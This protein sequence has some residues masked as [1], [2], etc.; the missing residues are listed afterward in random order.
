MT[1]YRTSVRKETGNQ[2][3][4]AWR[5]VAAFRRMIPSLNAYARAMTGRRDVR[6][7][8]SKTSNGSTD[9]RVISYRP[10][11]S[12]GR[13][14]RHDTFLCDER[15]EDLQ[16]LCPAC[17]Q[18]EDVLAVIYHEIAHLA[19][20]TFQKPPQG[21]V[22]GLLRAAVGDGSGGLARRAQ[23]RL[24]SGQVFTSYMEVANV[25]SPWLPHVFNA[26]EDA[27]VNNLMFKARPGV[28]LMFEALVEKVRQEGVGSVTAHGEEEV[29]SWV[30]APENSQ[31]VTA[32]FMYVAGYDYSDMFVESVLLALDDETLSN[33]LA[34]FEEVQTAQGVYTLSLPILV[35]CQQLGFLATPEEQEQ[36][37]LDYG[38]SDATGTEG[39]QRDG[40][41]PAPAVA[42]A[43]DAADGAS[44]A[45][46][47]AEGLLPAGSGGEYQAHDSESEQE[48]A[49]EAESR[50]SGTSGISTE[51]E[52][53][54]GGDVP[55]SGTAGGTDESSRNRGDPERGSLILD[56]LCGYFSLDDEDEDGEDDVREER[57]VCHGHFDPDAGEGAIVVALEQSLYFEGPSREV[58][59]L[60][61]VT[62]ADWECERGSNYYLDGAYELGSELLEPPRAALGQALLVMR[63][64]FTKNRRH[65]KRRNLTAGHVDASRLGRR[66]AVG[67]DRLFGK[68]SLPGK[69]SYD[70][71]I[72]LDCSGSTGADLS[73]LIRTCALA[74]GELC[75]G[76]G[77]DFSILAHTG[78]P[79]MTVDK[80]DWLIDVWL[81]EIK[82]RRQPWD[83]KAKQRLADLRS[84]YCNLD[85]HTLEYYRKLSQS[86]DATN[87]IILYYT[88]GSMP[89]ENYQEEK[90]IL[91]REIEECRRRGITLLCI[92]LKNDE[93]ANYGVDFV[94]IDG[95]EEIGLAVS[96]LAKLMK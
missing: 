79:D 11:L 86:S 56:K 70:V 47:G 37:D 22:E 18:R 5:A 46:A 30:D 9:G 92:S 51:K 96:A 33:L 26:L 31:L 88:D 10:P 7:V 62:F 21:E 14:I 82:N 4:L 76:V 90:E 60:R 89:C 73:R 38:G 61:V 59:K 64:A 40:A 91:I 69:R 63:A 53:P 94:R 67:D 54:D 39:V 36:V 87:K 48:G 66:V 27:R 8:A 44:S 71:T 75:N 74:Q 3:Q 34:G 28:R 15:G 42:D 50:D 13:S 24:N 95:P 23:D 58:G 17:A 84:M 55:E 52:D 81:F 43:G 19:Y 35:R 49:G 57:H 20:D 68:K 2:S 29:T 32:L 93:P 1:E 83:S 80:D 77:V 12:L 72:G 85:G 16:Q 45:V 6:V 41:T 78:M 25:I 65:A